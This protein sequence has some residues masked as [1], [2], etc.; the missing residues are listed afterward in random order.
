M[1]KRG[2]FQNVCRS[3]ASLTK[4]VY[5]LENEE[6]QEA[7]DDVLFLG[8]VQSTGGVWTAQLGINSYSTRFKLNT[9]AAVTVIG[10]HTSWLKDY[11]LV[12]LKQTLRRP[13][14]IQTPV[15]G[16]FQARENEVVS[17]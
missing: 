13:G 9:G 15:I 17:S 5:E 11:K 16:M 8:E 6:D 10:A 1:Q 4:K 12:K 14:N 2:H 7:V 3:S